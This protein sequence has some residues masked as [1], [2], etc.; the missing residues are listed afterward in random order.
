MQ[1]RH[2]QNTCPAAKK[3]NSKKKQ[4]GKQRKGWQFS[5]P[6][7]DDEE[8]EAVE[9]EIPAEKTEEAQE[10]EKQRENPTDNKADDKRGTQHRRYQATSPLRNFRFEQRNWITE[11]RN[12]VD[13]CTDR[14]HPWRVA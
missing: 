14:A 8:S 12:T 5:P 1:T 6:V 11:C 2:L 13:H 9:E 3:A 4:K 10:M 7:S